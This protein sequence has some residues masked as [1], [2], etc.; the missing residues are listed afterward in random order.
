M[1]LGKAPN[2][3]FKIFILKCTVRSIQNSAKISANQSPSL[4]E[5]DVPSVRFDAV[6]RL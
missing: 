6:N 4:L 5:M 3:S 1:V 2:I